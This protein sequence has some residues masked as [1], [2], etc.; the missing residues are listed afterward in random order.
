MGHARQRG[1]Q[2]VSGLCVAPSHLL[3]AVVLM[4]ARPST[5]CADERCCAV[6]VR[7]ATGWVEALPGSQYLPVH[8]VLALHWRWTTRRLGGPCGEPSAEHDGTLG[9]AALG[10]GGIHGHWSRLIAAASSTAVLRIMP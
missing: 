6:P 5:S 1:E 3:C 2:V 9:R 8:A 10:P 4:A 7:G